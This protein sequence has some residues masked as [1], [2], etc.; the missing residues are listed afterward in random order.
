MDHFIKDMICGSLS[1]IGNC[2]SG[3]VFDTVKVRMQ[4]DH[5]ITMFGS[6]RTIIKN[7]GF[8]HLFNGIYYPL[9]TI[10]VLNAIIF[11]SY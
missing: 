4:M 2:V 1:G 10:P 5:N 8:M 7:E 11:S 6:F 9:I 3:Y